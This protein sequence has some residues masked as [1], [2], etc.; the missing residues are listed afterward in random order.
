MNR[1]ILSVIFKSISLALLVKQLQM[2]K[3][4]K[5]EMIVPS[6]EPPSF[7]EGGIV[8]PMKGGMDDIPIRVN[9]GEVLHMT[10]KQRR[11]LEQIINEG[12]KN[13]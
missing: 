11:E 8:P 9:V 6:Q 13:E 7:M 3:I 2:R 12:K 1:N 5:G 4:R 10:E